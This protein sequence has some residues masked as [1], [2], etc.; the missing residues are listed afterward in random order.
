MSGFVLARYRQMCIGFIVV[1]SYY[2]VAAAAAA[3]AAEPMFFACFRPLGAKHQIYTFQVQ[4]TFLI[5]P[6]EVKVSRPVGQPVTSPSS[7]SPVV[8]VSANLTPL[9][10]FLSYA[11]RCPFAL[12]FGFKDTKNDL[13]RKRFELCSTCCT[14]CYLKS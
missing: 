7:W 4:Y 13:K 2:N 11:S 8:V 5:Q 9:K 6:A 14:H 1:H 10:R 12:P 3:A